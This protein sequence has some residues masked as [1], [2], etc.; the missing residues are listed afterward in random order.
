[1]TTRIEYLRNVAGFVDYLSELIRQPKDHPL[2]H[3]YRID[4]KLWAKY[5]RQNKPACYNV[6]TS[7]LA[8]TS[9]NDAFNNYYWI[10]ESPTP[11]KDDVEGDNSANS[12]VTTFA[13]NAECLNALRTKFHNAWKTED[14]AGVFVACAAILDWGGVYRGSLKWLIKSYDG[15]SLINLLSQGMEILDGGDDSGIGKFDSPL[16]MDSGLTK[17]YALACERS[18]IYDDRV[19]AALGFL[20]RKYLEQDRNEEVKEVPLNLKFACGGGDRNP[21]GDKLEFP[22]RKPGRMHA[23]SN[24]YANWILQSVAERTGDIFGRAEK[25][26]ALEAAL[27]MIGYRVGKPSSA[28]SETNSGKTAVEA[29]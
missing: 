6:E 21:S 18:I 22:R 17:V 24:L 19:G 28:S 12:A 27:F 3:A 20:A 16:R 29:P 13:A 14:P 1:M 10:A 5:L 23:R 25:L 26:R 11:Q 15:G 8:L 2:D 9:L 4:S 7:V